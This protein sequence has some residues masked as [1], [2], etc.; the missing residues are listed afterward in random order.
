MENPVT[1]K[2]GD[3]VILTGFYAGARPGTYG[4]IGSSRGGGGGCITFNAGAYRDGDFV[5]SSG[6][7]VFTGSF[8]LVPTGLI[9][10]QRFWRFRNG[11]VAAG[12]GEDFYLDVPLWEFKGPSPVS[13]WS[14]GELSVCRL[15]GDKELVPGLK[16]KVLIEGDASTGS[17]MRGDFPIFSFTN[18]D[19]YEYDPMGHALL[20]AYYERKL[21]QVFEYPLPHGVGVKLV[22][23]LQFEDILVFNTE[24]QLHAWMQAYGLS[25]YQG[26]VPYGAECRTIIPNPVLSTWMPLRRKS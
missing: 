13:C 9:H 22:V 26:E 5:L 3:A 16:E 24:A 14:A 15:I 8:E 12:N 1:P 11:E 23:K 10:R 18:G 4:V 21:I 20:V 25:F 19:R 2:A 17:Y 6:G 7:P